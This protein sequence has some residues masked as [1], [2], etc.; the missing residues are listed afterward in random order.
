MTVLMLLAHGAVAPRCVSMSP[1]SV[2]GTDAA[3]VGLRRCAGEAS[4][5]T[6]QRFA[7]VLPG[8]TEAIGSARRS[9]A[10]GFVAA[11]V[12]FDQLLHRWLTA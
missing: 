11:V 4:A 6:Y 5:W 10:A 3:F 1:A 12:A 8:I 2:T 9:S 7:V